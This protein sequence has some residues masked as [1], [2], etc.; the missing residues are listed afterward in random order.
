MWRKARVLRWRSALQLEVGKQVTLD[1]GLKVGA[2]TETVTAIGA[3]E[4]LK[5]A[6]ASVRGVVDQN[7]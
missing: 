3:A 5:T 6:D 4:L 7:P 1:V 2:N